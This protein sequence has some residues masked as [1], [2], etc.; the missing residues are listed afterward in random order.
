[1]LTC[2]VPTVAELLTTLLAAGTTLSTWFDIALRFACWARK[3][4]KANRRECQMEE[5]W[6]RTRAHQSETAGS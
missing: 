4:A 1:V 2:G 3:L 6:A 5:R